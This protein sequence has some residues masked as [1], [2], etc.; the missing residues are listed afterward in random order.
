MV[1]A[2][3]NTPLVDEGHAREG[4]AGGDVGSDDF[5]GS[6]CGLVLGGPGEDEGRGLRAVVFSVFQESSLGTV[7][8]LGVWDVSW[9]F[10]HGG[11]M[12]DRS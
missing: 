10:V 1:D 3:D 12:V 11:V 4:R 9:W 6:D 5:V 2:T 8:E 7:V